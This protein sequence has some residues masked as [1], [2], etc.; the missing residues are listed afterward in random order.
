MDNHID[1]S[2]YRSTWTTCLPRFPVHNPA[3]APWSSCVKENCVQDFHRNSVPRHTNYA[4]ST[5][6]SRA[7]KLRRD[8]A[9]MAAFILKKTAEILPFSSLS[10]DDLRKLG[11]N[12]SLRVVSQRPTV[13]AST[14]TEEE[15]EPQRLDVQ[16][17][18]E[19]LRQEIQTLKDN[20]STAVQSVKRI[21]L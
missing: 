10:N 17:E 6:F 19:H 16:V 12:T 21:E 11:T 4:Y 7:R 2:V 1:N 13:A 5:S 14:Q 9:R 8:R 18:N 20:L 15:D 3:R